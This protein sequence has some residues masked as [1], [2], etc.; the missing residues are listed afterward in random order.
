MDFGLREYGTAVQRFFNGTGNYAKGGV[1]VATTPA[2]N[3]AFNVGQLTY[4]I[5]GLYYSK[6]AAANLPFSSVGAG[7]VPLYV[8][9]ANTTVYYSVLADASGNLTTMQ[10]D[11]NG[12]IPTATILTP[13][14]GSLASVTVSASV[15][16]RQMLPPA[17][18]QTYVLTPVGQYSLVT[19]TTTAPHGL[20][21]G[22]TV[23]L[24]GIVNSNLN[25]QTFSVTVTGPNIFTLDNCDPTLVGLAPG[26][27]TNSS[28]LQ[29]DAGRAFIGYIKVQ[30]NGSTTFTPG[31]TLVTAP[32]V[33][34]SF[35][36]AGN[37]PLNARP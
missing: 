33:T 2:A 30:T 26:V 11:V 15:V 4:M 16:Q 6:A 32:G 23:Q 7:G 8:Q 20:Q 13:V 17:P 19:L 14:S 28:F 9:P 25:G 12:T 10:G 35:V 1:T 29:V 3:A 27:N 21:S 36:D 37:I 24:S 22:D 5:G 18:G 31:T 34:A